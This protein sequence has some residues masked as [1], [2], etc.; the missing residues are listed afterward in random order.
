MAQPNA[1]QR[2]LANQA[3]Q[4]VAAPIPTAVQEPDADSFI[5]SIADEIA[6][7]EEVVEA[8]VV[9]TETEP[10]NPGKEE[11]ANTEP[12]TAADWRSRR[13]H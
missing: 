4:K 7:V 3:S 10:E 12:A 13:R 1:Y 2:Y 8:D 9:T 11:A 5:K 6:A